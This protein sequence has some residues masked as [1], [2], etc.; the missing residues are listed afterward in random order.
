MHNTQLSGEPEL[1]PGNRNESEQADGHYIRWHGP[2]GAT[3]TIPV[4]F[5]KANF[6]HIRL[7]ECPDDSHFV[8]YEGFGKVPRISASYLPL[9][10]AHVTRPKYDHTLKNKAVLYEL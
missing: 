8:E 3:H 2:H 5:W 6:T 10:R 4:S 7:F 1:V 9:F